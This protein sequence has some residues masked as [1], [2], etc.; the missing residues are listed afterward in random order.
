MTQEGNVSHETW[1]HMSLEADT[2]EIKAMVEALPKKRLFK[3]A[4]PEQQ[5]ARL[6][7]DPRLKRQLAVE[8]DR[9]AKWAEERRIRAARKE[10]MIR[11]G[12]GR[13]VE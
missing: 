3:P 10:K 1:G 6:D 5:Q 9:E 4:T 2:T 12:W 11:H 7:E 13:D 8:R